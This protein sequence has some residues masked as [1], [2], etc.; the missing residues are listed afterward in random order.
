MADELQSFLQIAPLLRDILQEDIFVVVADRDKYI[1][2]KPGNKIDAKIEVGRRTS[3][4]DLLYKT[5][6]EGKAFQT[7]VPKEVLG[8][9]FRGTTYPIRNEQHEIVGGIEIGQNLELQYEIQEASESLFSGLE[10]TSASAQEINA[11]LTELS[12]KIEKLTD[13]TE[14]AEKQITDS[15]KIVNMMQKIATQSNLLGINA[16][17]EAARLGEAGKGFSVVAKEI[18]KLANTSNESSKKV[19][20]TLSEIGKTMKNIF[21]I[22]SETQ[23]IFSAQTQST[24]EISATIEDTTEHAQKMAEMAKIQ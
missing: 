6:R 12:K 4:K 3:E 9:P 17:I 10:E 24:E 19:A 7:V 5:I 13:N 20:E 11:N 15:N 16:S 2:Y 14:K 23:T 21:Q 18:Q 1:Y 8:I 22:I